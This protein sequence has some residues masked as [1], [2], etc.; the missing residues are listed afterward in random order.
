MTL[1]IMTFSISTICH[2]AKCAECR[3]L[4]IVM[5]NVAR[6]SVVAPSVQPEYHS[7]CRYAESRG[8]LLEYGHQ[9]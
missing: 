4:F 9:R 7:E 5:L 6:L 2:Y 1:S 3:V 8:T